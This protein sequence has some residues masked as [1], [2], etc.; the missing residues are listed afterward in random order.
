MALSQLRGDRVFLADGG[1]ETTLIFQRAIDLPLFAA[2]PLLD[3]AE[4]RVVLRDYFAPYLAATRERGAGFL[5][6]TVTS[7]AG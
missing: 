2:F 3:D 6:D 4:G 7:S 1:L 5:L